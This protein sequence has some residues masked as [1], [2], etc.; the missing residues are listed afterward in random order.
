MP[1]FRRS[2]Q[3]FFIAIDRR[4][5]PSGVRPPRLRPFD[6]LPLGLPPRFLPPCDKAV[7]MSAEMA[8]PSRSL[9]F[10]KSATNLFRSKV[11][12]YSCADVHTCEFAS[13][14]Y[15]LLILTQSNGA[16]NERFSARADALSLWL[17]K[18]GEV[19]LKPFEFRQV[20]V[21]DI[22]LIGVQRQVVLMVVFG[23]IKAAER[24]YLGYD[25]L[26]E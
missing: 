10:F 26:G 9:S 3:R 24:N 16:S 15:L 13:T 2:A 5:L 23:R 22:G 19:L 21:D 20:V 12:S 6:V 18:A 14:Q 7:P 25:C 17:I 11:S 8:R 1:F 4:L